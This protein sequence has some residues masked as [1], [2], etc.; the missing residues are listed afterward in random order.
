MSLADRA[1]CFV[2]FT[3]DDSARLGTFLAR[4]KWVTPVAVAVGVLLAGAVDG[5]AI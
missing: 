4:H 5:G 3:G 2:A 1:L